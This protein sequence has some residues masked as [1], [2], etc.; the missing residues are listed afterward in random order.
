[1]LKFSFKKID[2]DQRKTTE[3]VGFITRAKVYCISPL[4]SSIKYLLKKLWLFLN[5]PFNW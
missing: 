2:L 3:F 4:A 5:L 1:M